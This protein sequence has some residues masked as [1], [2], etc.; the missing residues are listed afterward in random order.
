MAATLCNPI[1]RHG[2][3]ILGALLA[4]PGGAF[5]VLCCLL[6]LLG[7]GAQRAA[8]CACRYSASATT[9]R[10]AD[11]LAGPRLG[12]LCYAWPPGCRTW[13]VGR[14][15]VRAQC[16]KCASGPR[17]STADRVASS[18]LC[19]FPSGASKSFTSRDYG[20]SLM[21]TKKESEDGSL[22]GHW[23]YNECMQAHSPPKVVMPLLEIGNFLPGRHNNARKGKLPS[24]YPHY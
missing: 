11:T 8:G 10:L 19:C 23:L 24:R 4:P 14:G 1:D 5:V 21:R 6:Y 15:G 12:S 7:Q 18:I 16:V 22:L 13:T 9:G 3:A 2:T 17:R 20:C